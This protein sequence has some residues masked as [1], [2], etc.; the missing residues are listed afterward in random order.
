MSW[1]WCLVQGWGRK[2]SYIF[3][4]AQHSFSLL[5]P[6]KEEEGWRL[7]QRRAQKAMH[8]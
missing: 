1:V 6:V 4:Y 3:G 5:S 2:R 8:V 7:S